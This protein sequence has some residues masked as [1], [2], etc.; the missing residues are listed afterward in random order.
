VSVARRTN[1]H[2]FIVVI[3]TF[4]H[5]LMKKVYERLYNPRLQAIFS[6]GEDKD[7]LPLPFGKRANPP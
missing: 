1:F 6:E 2:W 7:F 4:I 5:A 3:R